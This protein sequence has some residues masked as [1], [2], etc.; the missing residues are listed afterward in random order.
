MEDDKDA[1]LNEK[2]DN[3]YEVFV[4]SLTLAITAESDEKSA[5]VVPMLELLTARPARIRVETY[6]VLPLALY[7]IASTSK[8]GQSSTIGAKTLSITA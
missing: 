8:S 5:K 6:T 3:D 1:G 2:L 7:S 4:L